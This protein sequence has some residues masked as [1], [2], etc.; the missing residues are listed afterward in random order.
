M[1]NFWSLGFVAAWL[2]LAAVAQ[3]D[4]QTIT[5][6][7]TRV[8]TPAANVPAGVSV[9]TSQEIAQRGYVTLAVRT[10]RMCWCCWMACR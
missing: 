9:I 1:K 8:P 5:V 6:T 7:A 10:R 4:P 2:P 3:T